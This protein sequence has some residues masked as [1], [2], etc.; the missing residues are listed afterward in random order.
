MWLQVHSWSSGWLYGRL[1]HHMASS[2]CVF[3]TLHQESL[4]GGK[5]HWGFVCDKPRNSISYWAAP[6]SCDGSSYLG[7][8]PPIMPYEVLH[9]L[10][11]EAQEQGAVHDGERLTLK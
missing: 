9:R 10:E 1:S 3:S 11:F 2:C 4:L 5:D 8:A 6:C 7:D